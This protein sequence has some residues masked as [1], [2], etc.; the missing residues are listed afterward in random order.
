MSCL[1]VASMIG[2]RGWSACSVTPDYAV[3]INLVLPS[4]HAS[5]WGRELRTDHGFYDRGYDNK[6]GPLCPRIQL[7]NKHL[8][9]C[10]LQAS[11]E[12]KAAQDH[13]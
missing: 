12:S 13:G 7:I 5:V 9:P 3:I 11:A 8:D 4:H 1:S 2:N 10:R 6:I